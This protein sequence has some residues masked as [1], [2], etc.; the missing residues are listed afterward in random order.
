MTTSQAALEA[1]QRRPRADLR[2]HGSA[3]DVCA[4]TTSAFDREPQAEADQIASDA[5]VFGDMTG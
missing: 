2:S 3:Q 5:D 4:A 1:R